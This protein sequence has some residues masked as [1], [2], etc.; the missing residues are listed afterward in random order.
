MPHWG[1]K[2][3]GED[4]RLVY[5]PSWEFTGGGLVSTSADLA[6]FMKLLLAGEIVGVEMLGEMQRGWPME[7]PS[8]GMLRLPV[9]TEMRVRLRL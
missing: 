5:N 1:V 9:R 7:F 3:A 4:G 6:R 2:T 8:P